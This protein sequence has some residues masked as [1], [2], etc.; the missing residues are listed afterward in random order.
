MRA[1]PR[2][3]GV[4]HLEPL[5]GSPRFAGS[6]EA[7]VSAARR[8][9]RAL[10]AAGFEGIMIENFGDAPFVPSRVAP[11]TIA[12]MTACAIAAREA[13]P[14]A[15]LGVNVLRNDAGAALAIAAA[16][17][18]SMIRVNVHAGARVTDQGVIDG[19]AHRTLRKRR[20]LGA[21]VAILADVDVKHSAPLA[22]RPIG[23]EAEEVVER[24]LADAV[25]VTGSGTGRAADASDLSRVLAAVRAPV[26]VASG[27]TIATLEHLKRA[28]GV[29]VGTALRASG[30]AGDPVDAEL[31][32]RFSD[33]FFR[34]FA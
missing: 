33:A 16:T 9:A 6:I 26:L 19:E 34:A 14:K 29:V 17:G 11:V 28:H 4:V 3:I 31:A 5:P 1:V 15:M 25:L 8:D 30:R 10:E 23:E 2:L 22:A 32:K 7:V 27:A 18:A 12:A 20:E 24:G 21:D 13:A